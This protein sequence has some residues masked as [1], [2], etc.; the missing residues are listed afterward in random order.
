VRPRR[1]HPRGGVEERNRQ[2][3]P[4]R[5]RG[6][7]AAPHRC[8]SSGSPG[9]D[10]PC[11][12]RAQD[13]R[14][15]RAVLAQRSDRSPS[16]R[17]LHRPGHRGFSSTDP[18]S[19]PPRPTGRASNHH[20]RC[21]GA[22]SPRAQRTATS[23]AASFEASGTANT[24]WHAPNA[25]RQTRNGLLV[26]PS[27]L[28]TMRG[29]GAVIR[30]RAHPT[31]ARARPADRPVQEFAAE[32]GRAQAREAGARSASARPAAAR[33]SA[34]RDGRCAVTASYRPVP[35]DVPQ[36]ARAEAAS[37]PARH[38]PRDRGRCGSARGWPANCATPGERH[39]GRLRVDHR[40][41]AEQA[42]VDQ[43]EGGFESD[44]VHAIAASGAGGSGAAV[45]G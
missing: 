4:P 35:A 10:E 12:R 36:P 19:S 26:L 40:V 21:V 38:R 32:L 22:G 6:D 9:G 18:W 8:A 14:D 25:G 44:S 20:P 30:P 11:R 16:G 34:T 5:A 3:S 39:R 27:V 29:R 7:R 33:R 41:R 31:D 15:A 23:R 37:A 17:R 2:R 42:S 1:V 28:P 43:P 13:A 24:S 45:R